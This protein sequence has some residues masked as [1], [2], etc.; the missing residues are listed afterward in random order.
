[1]SLFL[2]G[3]GSLLPRD[4]GLRTGWKLWTPDA[5]DLEKHPVLTNSNYI[6]PLSFLDY[7]CDLWMDQCCEKVVHA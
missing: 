3:D 5:P 2:I 1:V 7:A 4:P 6:L